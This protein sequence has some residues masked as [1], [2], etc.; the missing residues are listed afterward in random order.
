LQQESF[1]RRF[2]LSFTLFADKGVQV[3][4]GEPDN[5]ILNTTDAVAELRWDALLELQVAAYFPYEL[6][7]FAGCDG[8]LKASHVLDAGC[9]NGYFLSKLRSYFPDKH[10]TGLDV[11]AGL[12]AAARQNA[13]LHGIEVA[14]SDFFTY[15]P[16]QSFDFVIMR[17]IVQHMSN[18][19]QI[20][21]QLEKIVKVGGSVV[22]VEPDTQ[23]FLN[24]PRTP[25]FERLLATYA[26]AT[27]QSNLNR[28][29][30]PNLAL[31]VERIEG[32][33]ICEDKTFI[34]PSVG[35]FANSTVMQIFSL[36]IDLFERTPGLEFPFDEARDELRAW[37]QN[38][39]AFSQVG[40]RI[41]QIEHL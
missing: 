32:W 21:R 36:W 26:Q 31:D 8:W 25:V 19:E 11:S 41:V 1:H 33:E 30:L 17:L 15:V 24:Y 16:T 4:P 27:A 10:F 5:P 14:H 39:T 6:S 29:S 7:F 22:I 20:F 37:G 3:V 23:S 18:L 35:P 34:A 40:I 9:G 28:A 13:R 2:K 38:E 12:V